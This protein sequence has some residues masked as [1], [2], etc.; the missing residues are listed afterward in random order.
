MGIWTFADDS[1]RLGR[2][3]STGYADYPEQAQPKWAFF[4][5]GVFQ[6]SVF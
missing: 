4:E 5:F 6:R 2:M 3:Y 1:L